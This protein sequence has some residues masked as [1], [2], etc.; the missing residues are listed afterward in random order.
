MEH[1][2]ERQRMAELDLQKARYE[3]LLA[4]RRY[5]AG[6][7]GNRLIAAQLER[8]WEAVLRRVEPCEARVASVS[9]TV[10]A[11]DVPD[12]A[13]LGDDLQA[14][15]N[16]L[17]R[18]TR[19]RRQLFRTLIINIIADVGEAAYE[20]ILTIHWQGRGQHSQLRLTKSKSGKYGCRMPE[21]VVGGADSPGVAELVRALHEGDVAIWRLG[22]PLRNLIDPVAWIEAV[23][24]ELRSLIKTPDATASM[25]RVPV[26]L[27]GSSIGF[28]SGSFLERTLVGL[29]DA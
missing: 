9:A 16:A 3:A 25:G 12:F 17:I 18:T 26:Q 4:E 1:Q 22:Q 27:F 13:E 15:W 20:V 19:A 23:G 14:A 29:R 6:D 10:P 8:N 11:A 7:R 5:A 2:A 21:E 28:K 24:P